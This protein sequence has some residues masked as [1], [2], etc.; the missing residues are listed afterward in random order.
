MKTEDLIDPARLKF[1]LMY[2]GL[3]LA[4]FELLRWVLI[5]RPRY[6]FADSPDIT[7][8]RV[9]KSP[10]YRKEVERLDKDILVA[11]CKWLEKMRVI[12]HGDLEAIKK[13]REHRDRIAHEMPSF[14]LSREESI[15]P[16]RIDEVQAMLHKIDMFWLE[17]EKDT[18]P[19]FEDVDIVRDSTMDVLFLEY[20]KQLLKDVHPS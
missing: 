14:L 1:G 19:D 10:Q 5:Q 9:R 17:I 20:M 7:L 12:D 15:E 8:S 18:N 6:F 11:S 13:M 4:A 3:Y 16:N 2:C